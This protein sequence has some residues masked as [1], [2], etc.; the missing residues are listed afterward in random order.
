[1]RKFLT[2]ILVVTAISASVAAQS[3]AISTGYTIQE[4]GSRIYASPIRR[5]GGTQS[6]R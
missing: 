2:A 6:N 3:G 1:M 5:S 4:D